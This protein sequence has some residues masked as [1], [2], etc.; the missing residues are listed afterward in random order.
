MKP[1]W[2]GAGRGIYRTAVW[3]GRVDR[4]LVDPDAYRNGLIR[5]VSPRLEGTEKISREE[6]K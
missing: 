3:G 4:V 5:G 1:F 2:E 6:T